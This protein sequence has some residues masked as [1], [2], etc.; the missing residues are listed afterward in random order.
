MT[1]FVDTNIFLRY[2]T[3]DDPTKAEACF[4]LLER[5][6][7]GDVSLTTSESVIAEIVYV[8]SSPRVYHLSRE[9][10]R[11]R[12]YPLL[13]LEGLKIPDRRKYFRALDLYTLHA[14]D[15]EDALTAATVEQ[16]QLDGLYSYD[17]DFDKVAGVTRLEP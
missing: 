13:A 1:Q 14:I 3:R 8:L 16:S 17:T 9:E 10:V 7:T 12:L 6:K 15:F 11:A 2:L 5:A 4:R